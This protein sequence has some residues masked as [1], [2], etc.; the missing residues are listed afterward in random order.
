MALQT[1]LGPLTSIHSLKVSV[2]VY[3]VHML[4]SPS[5]G[6]HQF[7]SHE[8]FN[9]VSSSETRFTIEIHYKFTA[10]TK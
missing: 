1:I 10:N 3:D 5:L 2:G 7:E 9:F 8:V 6:N 4:A